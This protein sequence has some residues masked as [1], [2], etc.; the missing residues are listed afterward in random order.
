MLPFPSDGFQFIVHEIGGFLLDERDVGSEVFRGKT[1][2]DHSFLLHQHLVGAIEN[3][4]LSKDGS[5]QVLQRRS[6]KVSQRACL[7][8]ENYCDLQ[9][10][11]LQPRPG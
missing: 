7:E 3:D 8:L 5:G 4:A 2:L 10:K 9:C 6:G 1:E 11:L